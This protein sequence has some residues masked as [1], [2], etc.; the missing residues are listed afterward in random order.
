MKKLKFGR[1]QARKLLPRRKRTDNK[2]R[3]GKILVIA[4]SKN[5]EGAAV[6]SAMAAARVGAGYVYLFSSSRRFLNLDHPDFLTLSSMKDFS[7][8]KFQAVAMGP[9]FREPRLIQEW[10]KK[11]LHV[12][13]ENVVLDAEALNE[14]ARNPRRLPKNWV[15]TPHEGELSR[16]IDRTP[17]WVKTHRAEATR[18]AQKKFG[19]TIVLK[20]SHTLI[21]DGEFF[22][23]IQSG[24]ASLGKAGTGD[25]LTGMIAGFMSQ[26]LTGIEAAALAA[27]LH[28]DIADHWCTEK[29]ILSLMASDLLNELPSALKGLRKI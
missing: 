24:N 12:D 6:M 28:G 17:A 4:G 16:L 2:T 9:G 23:E 8:I 7:H 22:F 5:M 21:F 27:F 18:M 26:G 19:C 3:G 14:L 13:F 29:D 15:L 1:T 11:L 10:I 25:V 20:G